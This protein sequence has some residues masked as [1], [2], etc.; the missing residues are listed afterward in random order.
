MVNSICA[1]TAGF[2]QG[3]GKPQFFFCGIC[4]EWHRVGFDDD[5]RNDES[6]FTYDQL[7]AKYGIGGWVEAPQPK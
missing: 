6:R 1:S 3:Q 4:G 7:D 5:C 2:K